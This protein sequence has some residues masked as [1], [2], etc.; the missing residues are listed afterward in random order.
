MQTEYDQR[1][2]IVVALQTKQ[3]QADI[4]VLLVDDHLAMRETLRMVLGANPAIVVIGEAEDGV[5]ALQLLS[6]LHPDVVVTDIEM[7]RLNGLE[8]TRQIRKLS[9]QTGVVIITVHENKSYFQEGLEAGATS[10]IP[11]RLA[12]SQLA[13]AVYAAA[14]R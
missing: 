5:Q 6:T 13:P 12:G 8:A 1:T 4:G 11:K 3:V 14:H 9:P 2:T 10:C 7:P